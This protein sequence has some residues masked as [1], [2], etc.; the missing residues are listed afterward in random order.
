MACRSARPCACW[1][2]P[3]SD[4]ANRLPRGGRT[5]VRNGSVV[6][7]QIAKGRVDA[8][9][10]GSR[11]YAVKIDVSPV[12]ARR[13]KAVCK[14]CAGSINSL[15]ELL[16]GRL[17]K[18]VMDRACRAGDGLFPSANRAASR[19]AV[20]IAGDAGRCRSRSATERKRCLADTGAMHCRFMS[21]QSRPRPL[22]TGVLRCNRPVRCPS[23]VPSGSG[24][25]TGGLRPRCAKAHG[26]AL[27]PLSSAAIMTRVPAATCPH[28]VE[29]STLAQGSRVERDEA[30]R[31]APRLR[32]LAQRHRERRAII[33]ARGREIMRAT[34]WAAIALLTV[35]S[36]VATPSPA[37]AGETPK[38]G[39]VLT[40]MI[41]ADAPP[42]LDG[43]RETTYA[44]VHSAAP[45]YS[46]LI[47]VNP[48]DPSSTT[49]F[50]CDLC[51]EIPTATD[52][53]RTYTF[54]I[55]QGVRFH[56]GTPLTAYDVVAS[57][58]HIIAP[59]KDVLSPRESHYMMVDRVEATDPNTVIFHLKFATSA[60]LPALAEPFAWIYAKAILDK[61]P[62]WYE[63][64]VM[65][66]GPFRFVS[67]EVGQAIKGERNPDYYHSG[68]PYLD[69]FIG[70]YAPKQAVRNDA[71]RAGRADAEFR[72][73]PPSV[74]DQL[75]QELG[76]KI[77]LQ[78]S[79]WNCNNLVTINHKRRPLDDLRV[80]RALAL[81]I[82][83]WHG[84][85]ALTKI[86][87]V[88]TVGG[89]VFPGSPL[90]A[91]RA[92][93]ET[94]VGYWPD[95]DKSRSEAKRLLKEAGAE[96]FGFE[97]LTRN[98]DQ[99][100]KYVAIW[101]IDE[102]SKIGLH[103]K[104]RV[105]PMGPEFDAMRSGNFDVVLEAN[106]NS[107]VNPLLDVQ[108][109][110]PHAV[111]VGNYGNYSDEEATDL[112]ERM[113]H[114]TDGASQRSLMRAFERR[115]LDTEAH[116]VVTTYWHRIV[117]LHAHVKGWKIGPSH[118]LNQDLANIWLDK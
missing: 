98:V 35:S 95:I 105:E 10:A 101:L 53:G 20:G 63:K 45:F 93:L 34:A 11:L 73:L 74:R 40:Y 25:A 90:A 16:Q 39:G 48:D 33:P 55:R 83:Q 118:Y 32:A 60:F 109:Y 42:S 89:I 19:G 13:W 44:T 56:D 6:N 82:D 67:Y 8:F 5:Y 77:V 50:V 72:G 80:R 64:H 115:V 78:S 113:L 76:G 54:R 58:Q 68:Q 38:R 81:A 18:G 37:A 75:Q 15:V 62:H 92:E 51:T 116:A 52:D 30:Y 61:D 59:P 1:P 114:E 36:V 94:L 99:P 104:Q 43:H 91:T 7:L 86:A 21:P 88:R 71:L 97:L 57:W 70:I 87:N 106:C 107:V 27:L 23:S 22:A 24:D 28:R 84:A 31:E 69:G 47:R 85:Q 117:P 17:S 46:V 96:G 79:D 49:D 65:G 102:W 108:K 110:L 12:P 29:R 2:A 100:Y 41:A 4:F 111:Y 9:V 26:G 14:D 112:Y 3:Y 103:V 66:S